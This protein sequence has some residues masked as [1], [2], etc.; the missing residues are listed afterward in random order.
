MAL[1]PRESLFRR[2]VAYSAAFHVAI[3]I[4]G[5]LWMTLR[6]PPVLIAP[7]A[8]VDLIGGGQFKPTAPAPAA[9]PQA[10]APAP[11]ADEKAREREPKPKDAPRSAMKKEK[12]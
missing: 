4:A 2:M 8:V 7:V 11:K 6:V 3:F 5:A 10:P 9:A 1:E 12:M